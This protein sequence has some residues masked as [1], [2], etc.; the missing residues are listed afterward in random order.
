M[1]SDNFNQQV[2]AQ[3]TDSVFIVLLTFSSDDLEDDIRIASDPYELLP[4]ANVLGVESNGLEYIFI[5]FKITLPRD[6]KTGSVSATLKV[7]NVEREIIAQAR[8][9][10]KPL[11]VRI[12]CVLSNDVDAI[13]LDY[14]Y[15]KLENVTYDQMSISGELTLDYWDL[16]PFPSGRFTPSQFPG[17]F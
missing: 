12:Q 4:V 8:S 13:E 16:E 6:D 3:D 5:P 14:D 7:D 15:F 10:R 17:M 9:I 11:S 2:F 1:T